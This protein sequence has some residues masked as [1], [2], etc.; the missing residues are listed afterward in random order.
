M[1]YDTVINPILWILSNVFVIF[2]SLGI[3]FFVI[4]Y[5]LFLK[6][7]EHAGG[8]LVMLLMVMFTGVIALVVIGVISNPVGL[9][10]YPEDVLV[11]RPA[12]RVVVYFGVFYAILRLDVTLV[13]RY[14]AGM[15]L[16]FDVRPRTDTGPQPIV[17][18]GEPVHENTI[19]R[20]RKTRARR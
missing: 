18:N 15:A 13:Q 9:L 14:R 2:V 3:L 11:W 10:A 16:G 5:G 20:P 19:P 12:V 6:W 7:W 17:R 1:N 4:F 8:R